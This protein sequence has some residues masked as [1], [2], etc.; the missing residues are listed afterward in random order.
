MK[1]VKLI[2]ITSIFLIL[3]FILYANWQSPDG[4]LV[5]KIDISYGIAGNAVHSLYDGDEI[6]PAM[7]A[8]IKTAKKTITFESY[9]YWSGDIGNQFVEALIERAQ[10]GVKAHVLVDWVGSHEMQEEFAEKLES[11]GVQLAFFHPLRWYNIARMN[12][13]THRKILVVD[14]EVGF[15]GGVGISDDWTGNGQDPKRWRDSHFKVEGPAVAYLQG[16]FMD[17]WLKVRPE[18]LDDE[19]YF[20]RL[21]VKGDS[22]AQVFI[23]SLEEESASMR[24]MYVMTIA[25]TKKTLRLS[26]AYFVPDKE[27]VHQLVDAKKRGVKVQIIVP[28]KLTDSN[29]VRAASR[30][31][32]GDL[33]KAGIEIYEY[34]KAKYHC[35]VMVADDLFVSVGST[36]FDDRSFRLNEEANLNVMDREFAAAETAAFEKDLA[37]SKQVTLADWENRPLKEK[38]LEKIAVLLRTQL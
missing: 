30:A 29:V 15:T 3:A 23:S 8:A 38:L 22:L 1:N 19:T 5:Q 17:N 7:L 9:I 20:P 12:N 26:S 2:T 33:L 25:A 6:F 36:N 37:S 11:G 4:K 21:G 10:A 31:L 32:W 35:K 18:V 16:A 24:L 14:G 27:A 28:G 13:R 34:Q